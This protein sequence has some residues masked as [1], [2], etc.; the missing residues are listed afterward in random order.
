LTTQVIPTKFF[1]EPLT[2]QN[3][4]DSFDVAVHSN[5]VLDDVQKFNNLHAQLHNEASHAISG[6]TLTSVNYGQTVSLLPEH[7]GDTHKIVQA[8]MRALSNLPKPANAA[9]GLRHFH[10]SVESHIRGLSALG[11][12]E[13]SYSILLV[14]IMHDK[15][16]TDTRLDLILTEIGH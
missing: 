6:F 16:P 4:W 7:F 10:D 9:S 5:P 3:F 11:I 13:E 12:S 8:Y 1:W 2:W 15:L 14:T